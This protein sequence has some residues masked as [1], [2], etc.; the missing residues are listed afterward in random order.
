MSDALTASHARSVETTPS[1]MTWEFFLI[2]QMNV[3]AGNS[4][5]A[6]L[7][8]STE[9]P[10]TFSVHLTRRS[11]HR[12][13]KEMT[14]ALK[15]QIVDEIQ[16]ERLPRTRAHLQAQLAGLAHTGVSHQV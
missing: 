11:G 13:V 16:S 5:I 1:E 2:N 3:G 10:A 8:I 4:Q 9:N 12:F 6:F 14:R 7:A 15:L